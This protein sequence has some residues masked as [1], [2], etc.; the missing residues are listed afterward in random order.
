[1]AVASLRKDSFIEVMMARFCVA[2]AKKGTTLQKIETFLFFR[3]II[4]LSE[5]F[6]ETIFAPTLLQENP[7]RSENINKESLPVLDYR[8]K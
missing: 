7:E 1:M 6:W 5:T 4:P 8:W 2:D 3:P